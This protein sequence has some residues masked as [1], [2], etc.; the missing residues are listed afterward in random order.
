MTYT[1]ELIRARERAHIAAEAMWDSALQATALGIML[2]ATI[3]T[4]W[5]IMCL[6][7]TLKG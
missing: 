5:F 3:A 2:V 7:F 1:I 4:A 6:A